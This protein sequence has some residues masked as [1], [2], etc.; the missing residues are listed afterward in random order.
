[1]A[2]VRALTN[3]SFRTS[4]MNRLLAAP[5]V[6]SALFL[7]LFATVGMGW[8]W[9]RMGRPGQLDPLHVAMLLLPVALLVVAV[10]RWG[11]TE[12]GMALTVWVVFMFGALWPAYYAMRVGG[13]VGGAGAQWPFA[14]GYGVTYFAVA[15]LSVVWLAAWSSYLAP[16]PDAA[17]EETATMRARILALGGAIPQLRV[18]E[19]PGTEELHVVY[20][21]R[22]GRRDMDVRLRLDG[23]RH[24][25]YSRVYEGVAG[26][27]PFTESEK[28]MKR[29][30]M[31]AVELHPD[32]DVIWSAR[33]TVV[34]RDA[35]LRQQ[36][37]LRMFRGEVELPRRITDRFAE[38]GG[39][40][41][42][43]HLLAAMAQQS[44][45]EWRGRLLF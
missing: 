18:V 34:L 25:V 21:F 20:T 23:A 19:E 44:G 11:T 37:G 4:R 15:F 6:V 8:I 16:F 31:A 38:D 45:W 35:E 30:P 39:A 10:L 29:G 1:M 13:A 40:E 36:L 42:L 2:A 43:P 14:V 33:R 22:D 9:L 12:N 32:A 26:D 28:R 5:V 3:T 41:L 24:R 17:V 27:R 7:L